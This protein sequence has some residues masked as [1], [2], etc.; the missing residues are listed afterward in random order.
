MKTM[1]D[2]LDVKALVCPACGHNDWISKGQIK[3]YSVSGEWFEL[4]ECTFCGLKATWPQPQP[5]EIGRYYAS[6]DYISH[7]DTRTG[8]INQLY[9][10]ARNYMMRRKLNWVNEASGRTSGLL[11]DV[12]AGTGHFARYMMDHGWSVLALEPDDTARRVASQKLGI[13]ILPLES[14]ADQ[15]RQSYDVIT[16]WHVLEHVHDLTG[17]IDHFH[18]LLKQD[19]VLMIAVPN[20]TSVD[21]KAYGD[22]WAAYD[23]PRHLWHFSPK[24]MQ[25]LLEQH[26]FT[27]HQKITMP[28][29]G[30]Y[31]SMLSEKYKASK[32]LGTA[33]AFLSGVKSLLAG[34]Q[35]VDRG[36]SII[37][38]SRK[39]SESI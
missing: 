19:G 9:H 1:G 3:D 4:R 31:V 6:R 35:Q 7:S 22:K 13:D 34:K 17:Y 29:D 10:R 23:V 21:A 39:N 11:L 16:L 18:K 5:N 14:L 33:S 30:F 12:G 8:L 32:F 25:L 38:V 20:H 26:Q 15:A 37:Y 2:I 27:L 36:S 28:L 24:S